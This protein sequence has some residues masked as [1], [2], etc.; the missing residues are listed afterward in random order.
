M[1]KLKDKLFSSSISLTNDKLEQKAFNTQSNAQI[2]RMR[3][4]YIQD[5]K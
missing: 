1:K 4:Q 2:Q 5:Y 3:K